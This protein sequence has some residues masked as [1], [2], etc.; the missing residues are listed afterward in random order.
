MVM[1]KFALVLSLVFV[2]GMG[3]STMATTVIS[4]NG[5]QITVVDN[6]KKPCAAG[7]TCTDCKAKADGC[8]AAC[9]STKKADCKTK[10]AD[11]EKKCEG[12][13]AEAKPGCCGASKD[14]KTAT[15]AAPAEP[16]K[17]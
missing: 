10:S 12:K 1:K 6:D 11:G 3:M 15:P 7:C 4:D 16:A 2:A 9:D 13:S 8:K 17:K 14:A 5:L